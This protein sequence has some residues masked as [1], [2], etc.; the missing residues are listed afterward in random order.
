LNYD[1]AA[2]FINGNITTM[3]HLSM[4]W[5][6]LPVVRI[7]LT[8]DNGRG[9]TEQYVSEKAPVRVALYCWSGF[10]I[11]WTPPLYPVSHH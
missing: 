3:S 2:R 1:F 6:I 11:Q 10:E 8:V 7:P 4:G 5:T 9:T